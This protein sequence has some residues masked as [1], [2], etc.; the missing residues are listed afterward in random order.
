MRKR[1][2]LNSV[3][4]F[5]LPLHAATVS[6][7]YQGFFDRLKQVNKGQFQL[8]EI[9]FSVP[10]SHDCQIQTGNISTEKNT[11]P[12]TYTSEQRLF[13][14]FDENL[15]SERALINIEV[16]G[17]SAQCSIAMQVRAKQA[18]PSY[19]QANLLQIKSEMDALLDRM[20]GFPMRYFREP[21]AGLNIQ[22]PSDTEVTAIIDGRSQLV[23]GQLQ[24]T[25]DELEHLKRLEFSQTPLLISPW[26]N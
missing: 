26:I 5:T 16:A 20:Q 3:L 18:L 22:F 15:K 24:L 12:L 25:N 10:V 9:A 8:V 14:P 1:L 2:L 13:I 4:L 7:E 6:L 11:Y 17:D 21:I 19:D 23:R